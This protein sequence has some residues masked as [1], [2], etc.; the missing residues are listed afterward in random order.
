MY[1]EKAVFGGLVRDVRD[2]RV[3]AGTGGGFF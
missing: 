2:G 1:Y 3:W